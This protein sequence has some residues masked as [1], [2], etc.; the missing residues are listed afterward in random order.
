MKPRSTGQFHKRQQQQIDR[1][2]VSNKQI[3][4]CIQMYI[5]YEEWN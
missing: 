4:W 2:A 3:L 5:M 1:L